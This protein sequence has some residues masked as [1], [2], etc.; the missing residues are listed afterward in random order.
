MPRIATCDLSGIGGLGFCVQRIKAD[1]N[2]NNMLNPRLTGHFTQ[3]FGGQVMSLHMMPHGRQSCVR[4]IGIAGDHALHHDFNVDQFTHQELRARGEFDQA[5]TW[6]RIAGK[7]DGPIRR[8]KAQRQGQ[9]P[10]LPKLFLWSVV[11]V[12]ATADLNTPNGEHILGRD[13]VDSNKISR[14]G[15][16]PPFGAK[17]R[18]VRDIARGQ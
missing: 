2:R 5:L 7:D 11:G 4:G 6:P 17:S 14:M 9:R 8:V 15:Q 10:V 1:V 18:C 13:F 16:R 12:L 3:L